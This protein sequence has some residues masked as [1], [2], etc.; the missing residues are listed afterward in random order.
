[1]K[2]KKIQ[3]ARREKLVKLYCSLEN[4]GRISLRVEK[5]R[6]N[7]FF[8]KSPLK[9]I[10]FLKRKRKRKGNSKNFE[11]SQHCN[12]WLEILILL[13][14]CLQELKKNEKRI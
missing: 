7:K 14:Y 12:S 3:T 1:M 4:P 2:H 13:Q 11:K 9:Q 8:E 10:F 5:S 6:C